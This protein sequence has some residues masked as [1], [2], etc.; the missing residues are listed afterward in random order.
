[1]HIELIRLRL[2]TLDILTLDR[3]GEGGGKTTRHFGI[4]YRQKYYP[5]DVWKYSSWR[6]IKS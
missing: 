3:P 5:V 4:T 6:Y 1:M 2:Y